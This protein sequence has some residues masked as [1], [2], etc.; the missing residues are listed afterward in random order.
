MAL[1]SKVGRF[2]YCSSF[3]ALAYLI[4]GNQSRHLPLNNLINKCFMSLSF[5]KLAISLICR[6]P[7]ADMSMKFKNRNVPW[8]EYID[9]QCK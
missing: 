5:N 9:T 1:L 8:T 6:F 7:K 3:S 4:Q 2:F